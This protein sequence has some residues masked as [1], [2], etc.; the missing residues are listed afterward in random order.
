M[1]L[2]MLLDA[3]KSNPLVVHMRAST[4]DARSRACRTAHSLE[5]LCECRRK[6]IFRKYRI[7]RFS[8]AC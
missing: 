4:L 3:T 2:N 5:E 7:Q 6:I 8:I 1:Q